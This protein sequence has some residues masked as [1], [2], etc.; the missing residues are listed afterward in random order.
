M[1]YD[2][3][4]TIIVIVLDKPLFSV[5]YWTWIMYILGGENPIGPFDYQLN[6]NMI[7]NSVVGGKIHMA[8]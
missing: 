8:M 5:K 6:P 7:I 3:V 4:F 2:I 1:L